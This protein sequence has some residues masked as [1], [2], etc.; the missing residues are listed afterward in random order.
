MTSTF[1]ATTASLLNLTPGAQIAVYT[2]FLLEL[3][4]FTALRDPVRDLALAVFESAACEI[5][6]RHI[7]DAC[8]NLADIN[9]YV[10][11]A[12]AIITQSKMTADERAKFEELLAGIDAVYVQLL[13]VIEEF[14]TIMLRFGRRWP[15][16]V[17]V[18]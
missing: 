2:L 4:A 18:P 14:Q 7:D 13:E 12:R 5:L 10:D 11:T 1:A 15:N 6:D 17:P 3:N 16:F 9:G 8:T